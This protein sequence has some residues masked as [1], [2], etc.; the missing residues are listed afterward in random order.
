MP[1]QPVQVPNPNHLLTVSMSLLKTEPLLKSWMAFSE[2]KHACMDIVDE[3]FKN[4]LLQ[5]DLSIERPDKDT[6]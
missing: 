2:A 6:A 3:L 4:L 1:G 5:Y